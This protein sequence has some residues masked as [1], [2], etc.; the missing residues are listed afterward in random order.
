LYP[1]LSVAPDWG[2]GALFGVGGMLGIYLGARCQRYVPARLIKWMLTA[3]ILF[4]AAKY[5]WEFVR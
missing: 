4:T 1:T 2:L 3:I 5:V